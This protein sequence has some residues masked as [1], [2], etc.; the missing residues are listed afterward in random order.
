MMLS[1]HPIGEESSVYFAFCWFVTCAICPKFDV[2]SFLNCR[3]AITF[4]N[5]WA[6]LFKAS[7]S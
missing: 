2:L 4:L 7:L 5:I 1:D 3:F 6:Q